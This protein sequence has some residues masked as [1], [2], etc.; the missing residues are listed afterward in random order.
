M[1][2]VGHPGFEKLIPFPHSDGIDPVY[3]GAGIGFERR[4]LDDSIAG[5]EDNLVI[6]DIVTVIK[7]LY[8]DECSDAVIRLNVDN[9]LNCPSLAVARTLGQ[10]I[11]LLPVAL[12]LAGKEEHG[13]MHCCHIHMLN[14]ILFPGGTPPLAC[15]SPVL[16]AELGQGRPLDVAHM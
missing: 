4:L 5:A 2:A 15:P 11:D 10:V 12:A 3:P 6:V 9:I 7:S 16:T 14:E 8:I 1:A 13:V